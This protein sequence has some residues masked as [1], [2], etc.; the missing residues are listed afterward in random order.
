MRE[1]AIILNGMAYFLS[2]D[3]YNLE[4]VYINLFEKTILNHES[5]IILLD[6]NKDDKQRLDI[7]LER[8]KKE[9]IS[10]PCIAREAINSRLNNSAK[11][12]LIKTASDIYLQANAI[13]TNS[14]IP[15]GLTC[16][17]IDNIY[18][19]EK[20][21]L[22]DANLFYECLLSIGV[23]PDFVLRTNPELLL[24]IKYSSEY[25]GFR[26]VYLDLIKNSAASLNQYIPE[27]FY[28]YRTSLL[29]K[30]HNKPKSNLSSSSF[31]NLQF[32]LVYYGFLYA[33]RH[34]FGGKSIQRS[35][36]FYEIIKFFCDSN[37]F[38]NAQATTRF[39]VYIDS[40]FRE[41]IAELK[42]NLPATNFFR[43]DIALL[44]DLRNF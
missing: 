5:G 10:R 8:V 9:G 26:N 16:N 41:Q 18:E 2:R 4:E 13:A 6:K 42:H 3:E 33:L 25:Q 43:G 31:F 39:V 20:N 22:G 11:I 36:D 1:N 34:S 12:R 19:F 14:Y 35:Q 15:S 23:M 37:A 7:I 21:I 40:Y 17:G 28:L 24:R 27:I 30:G 29:S 38:S 44:Y 32:R